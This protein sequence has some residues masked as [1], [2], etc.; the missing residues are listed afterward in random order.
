MRVRATA[1]SLLI[2]V[3]L[4]LFVTIPTWAQ[5]QSALNQRA[6]RPSQAELKEILKQHKLW[7]QSNKQS[8]SRADLRGA[9][10]HDAYLNGANLSGADLSDANLSG[11]YLWDADLSWANLFGAN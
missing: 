6:R 4:C 8:G 7:L 5:Q 10:L 11:P 2:A 3:S 9:D 1:S